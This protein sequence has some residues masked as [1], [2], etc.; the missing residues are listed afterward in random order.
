[1]RGECWDDLWHTKEN[2]N[3][4]TLWQS[5]SLFRNNFSNRYPPQDK[6]MPQIISEGSNC[7][8]MAKTCHIFRDTRDCPLSTCWLISKLIC[9][10]KTFF[11]WSRFLQWLSKILYYMYIVRWTFHFFEVYDTMQHNQWIGTLLK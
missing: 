4:M 1:M 7:Y 9:K 11:D 3:G 8:F 10:H 6:V 5:Q 2:R